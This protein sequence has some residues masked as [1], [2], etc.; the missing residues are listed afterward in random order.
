[1]PALVRAL[2]GSK[3]PRVRLAVLEHAKT[4]MEAAAAGGGGGAASWQLPQ[5]SSGA[6]AAAAAAAPVSSALLKCASRRG[7]RMI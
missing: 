3:Q 4:C 1:M 5:G 7:L 2:D 6:A